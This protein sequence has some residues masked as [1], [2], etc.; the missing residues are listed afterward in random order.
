[1]TNK[2]W[3]ATLS[4]EVWFDVIDWLYHDYGKRYTDSR[5]AI[6]EWLDMEHTD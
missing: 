6:I 1:M 3:L 4:A 5:Q 2:E